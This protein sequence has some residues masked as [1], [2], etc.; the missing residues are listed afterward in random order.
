M[1]NCI[2]F[3][4]I[5]FLLL[6]ILKINK[7]L[8]GMSNTESKNLEKMVEDTVK[9]VY[10]ADINAIRNLSEVSKKLQSGGLEIPG[11]LKVKGNLT[12]DNNI[13]TKTA[14]ISSS[15]K[16]QQLDIVGTNGTTHLNYQN[17]GLNYYRGSQNEFSG[18]LI[19]H[20]DVK[21][22]TLNVT[23]KANCKELNVSTTTN[24]KELNVIGNKGTTHLNYRNKG[25]NYFRGSYNQFDQDVR[26][27]KYNSLRV[28][29]G[30]GRSK[31]WR[32]HWGCNARHAF[33]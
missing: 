11:D 4:F 23:S 28:Y 3:L 13:N 30:C 27:V 18:N 14:N 2:Y 33:S 6:L 32:L 5:T 1:N 7:T 15:A 9:K 10:L 19:T 16:C 31:D 22:K 26:L 21:A 29:G 17:K 24:C 12:V 20:G 8:E 25:E